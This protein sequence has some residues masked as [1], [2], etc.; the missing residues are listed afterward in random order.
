MRMRYLKTFESYSEDFRETFQELIYNCENESYKNNN[1]EGTLIT[2]DDIIKCINNNG[3]IYATIVND[4]PDNDPDKG[5][6]PLDID[7]DGLISVSTDDGNFTVN[8]KNVE[9]IEL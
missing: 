8:L 1:E 5:L 4:N 6:K 7:E 3:V 9:R 2:I